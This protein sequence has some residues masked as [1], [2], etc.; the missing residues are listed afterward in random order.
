MSGETRAGIRCG[1]SGWDNRGGKCDAGTLSSSAE[2]VRVTDIAEVLYE[3]GRASRHWLREENS[4][5]LFKKHWFRL[6]L[7]AECGSFCF[8]CCLMDNGTRIE[9]S[10]YFRFIYLFYTPSIACTLQVTLRIAGNIENTAK[11]S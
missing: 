4:S 1:V 5:L 6:P 11:N 3:Q 10:R 2:V 7:R 8:L 9:R